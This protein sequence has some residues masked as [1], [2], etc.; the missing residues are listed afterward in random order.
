MEGSINWK[1]L[2]FAAAIVVAGAFV[3]GGRYTAISSQGGMIYVV[4]RYNGSVRVCREEDCKSV[5]FDQWK[6]KP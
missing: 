6:V 4:D 2:L 1:L 5:P 3:W